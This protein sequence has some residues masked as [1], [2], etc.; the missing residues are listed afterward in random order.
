MIKNLK[1]MISCA[2]AS[3][4]FASPA[5]GIIITIDPGHG[6]ENHGATY[7]YNSELKRVPIDTEN[8]PF[9]PFKY[10]GVKEIFEKDLNLKISKFLR[11]EL[12]KYKD[13]SGKPVSVYLTRENDDTLSLSERI[14]IGAAKNSDLIISIHNNAN[15]NHDLRGSLV[16]ATHSNYNNLYD[17]E[18]KIAMSILDKFYEILNFQRKISPADKLVK[19]NVSI[20]TILDYVIKNDMLRKNES[21]KKMIIKSGILEE[22]GILSLED[23]ISSLRNTLKEKI[24]KKGYLKNGILRRI[25]NDG[26]T[27]A[28]GIS[29][30]D[31]YGIIRLGAMKGIPSI[32]LECCYMDNEEDYKKILSTDEKL[33]KLSEVIA[34]GIANYFKLTLYK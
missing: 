31:W 33:R 30:T 27:Y 14:E 13:E 12:R 10:S 20:D 17:V 25:S 11:E 24:L 3:L 32:I 16:I 9:D 8:E 26:S 5:K 22:Y 4:L 6:G 19:G 1:K 23:D 18:E 7:Y 28:D 34:E 21:L 2:A 29:I 15:E